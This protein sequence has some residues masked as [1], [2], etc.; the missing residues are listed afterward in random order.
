MSAERD[1]I[2]GNKQQERQF[3]KK[4]SHRKTV[5]FSYMV[6]SQGQ[7][8]MLRDL[9]STEKNWTQVTLQQFPETLCI[10][11]GEKTLMT[12]LMTCFVVVVQLLSCV[13]LFLTSGTVV[14]RLL[15]PWDFPGKNTG[16]G[17]HFHF[18]GVILTDPGIKHYISVIRISE[19]AQSCLTFCNP[20]NSS[21]PGFFVHG[22]FQARILEWV[23]IPFSRKSS[24][25]RDQ[26]RVSRI[27][28]RHFTL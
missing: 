7:N 2:M 1:H 18:Q 12:S 24:R 19:V 4:L 20:M 16:M 28:G 10:Q 17:C 3:H 25:P 26:T 13:G 27:V 14:P 15:C 23:A 5:I 21:L 22:M 6:L 11:F 8:K 9:F